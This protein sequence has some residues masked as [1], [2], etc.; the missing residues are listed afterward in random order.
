MKLFHSK[1]KA[2]E[3]L[4]YFS[5]YK[6]IGFFPNAQGQVTHKPLVGS[7]W[8]SNPFEILW[9]YLLSA[10]MKK[11][12]SKMNE[13]EWSQHY[14][15]IFKM[16]KGSLLQ[17]VWWDLDEIQTHASFKETTSATMNIF[18]IFLFSFLIICKRRI[19]LCFHNKKVHNSWKLHGKVNYLI[20]QVCFSLVGNYLRPSNN[21][22]QLILT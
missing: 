18:R 17:N 4:Q 12:Q 14:S 2:L 11:I 6:C 10:R 13:V 19:K 16:L 21:Y 8:I 7:C 9:V 15:L 1:L 5:H 20:K 3:W 22:R